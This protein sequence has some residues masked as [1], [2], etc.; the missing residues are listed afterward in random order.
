MKDIIT[1]SRDVSAIVPLSVNSGI[2]P[3]CVPF[4]AG[5]SFS[6]EVGGRFSQRV[7]G[8]WRH[9]NLDFLEDTHPEESAARSSV[10]VNNF[11]QQI[12][13]QLFASSNVNRLIKESQPSSEIYRTLMASPRGSDNRRR[14]VVREVVSELYERQSIISNTRRLAERLTTE[15]RTESSVETRYLITALNTILRSVTQENKLSEQNKLMLQRITEHCEKQLD[16]LKV[17]EQLKQLTAIK[18]T[19]RQGD[20]INKISEV[21]SALSVYMHNNELITK[22]VEKTLELISNGGTLA[23]IGG[24]IT[25]LVKSVPVQSRGGKDTTYINRVLKLVETAAQN[26]HIIEENSYSTE[27]VQNNIF[28][29]LN[30]AYSTKNST[31]IKNILRSALT[32]SNALPV[33]ITE[34]S[35]ANEQIISSASD[36]LRL[37]TAPAFAGAAASIAWQAAEQNGE[38]V[39]LAGNMTVLSGENTTVGNYNYFNS[40]VT[41]NSFISGG[42][43][44]FPPVRL[45]MVEN[46]SEPESRT[47]ASADGMSHSDRALMRVELMRSAER[48]VNSIGARI[49]NYISSERYMGS[50]AS[51]GGSGTAYAGASSSARNVAQHLS[52]YNVSHYYDAVRNFSFVNNYSVFSPASRNDTTYY[53][54]NKKMIHGGGAAN[55]ISGSVGNY[56]TSNNFFITQNNS[57]VS[58]DGGADN[59]AV[60]TGRFIPVALNGRM[61]IYGGDNYFIQNSFADG[62]SSIT[63]IRALSTDVNTYQTNYS[64]NYFIENVEERPVARGR[65]LPPG[66]GS[67]RRSARLVIP[68]KEATLASSADDS[69]QRQIEEQKRKSSSFRDRLD[70][71]TLAALDNAIAAAASVTSAGGAKKNSTTVIHTEWDTAD[72]RNEIVH[73]HE[74]NAGSGMAVAGTLRPMLG[75]SIDTLRIMH[76][77]LTA[78]LKTKRTIAS[79]ISRPAHIEHLIEYAGEESKLPAISDNKKYLAMNSAVSYKVNDAAEE[80]I[81]LVPPV[82]M[83]KFQ[84]QSGYNRNLPPIEHHQK[85]QPKPAEPAPAKPTLNE[86]MEKS[87][88]TKTVVTK[89]INDLSREDIEQLA[90]KI[91]YQIENRI[92]NERRRSG[93]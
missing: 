41:N 69:R 60:K 58:V 74:Q 83:D 63:N 54:I 88:I 56:N 22:S 55:G 19:E 37:V 38:I 1:Q 18:E 73:R 39:P 43:G 75:E 84:M 21:T 90:D 82:A 11:T 6:A 30:A 12:L 71:K 32:G 66:V 9:L 50:R 10:T 51:D 7:Y 29:Q 59:A 26:T 27:N 57:S 28:A 64:E 16:A 62:D 68:E 67:Y 23:E 79:T 65:M 92:M 24:S 48:A 17:T 85:Q 47:A 89:G 70:E 49:T 33:T 8:L 80:M 46:T 42:Y 45:D 61:S 3:V 36:V 14:D 91:Y 53:N 25:E 44:D 86:K 81:M 2:K 93:F 40:S 31:E 13:F 72:V 87:R 77:H 5:D 76:E 35:L 52:R 78:A 20:I 4:E 15:I 34:Q